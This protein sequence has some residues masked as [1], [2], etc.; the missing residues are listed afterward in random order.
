MSKSKFDYLQSRLE[1]VP[2]SFFEKDP[3]GYRF[4]VETILM[5]EG[6]SEEEYLGVVFGKLENG[7][8]QSEQNRRLKRH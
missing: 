3:D 6:W 5:E 1:S 4:V 2:D 7:E 8:V